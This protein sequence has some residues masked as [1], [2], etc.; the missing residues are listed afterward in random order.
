MYVC[1]C[2]QFKGE[3]EYDILVQRE[4]QFHLLILLKHLYWFLLNLA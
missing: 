3:N 2:E 4:V 1:V